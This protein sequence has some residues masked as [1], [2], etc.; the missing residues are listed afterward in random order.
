MAMQSINND[1]FEAEVL[2]S[3]K[4]VIVEFF[5]D[6]CVPCKRMSPVLAELEDEYTEVKFVKLNI[7]FG[8]ETAQKY[9][10]MSSPTFV[11]FK[12]GNEIKRV[13][14]VIARDEFED[15]I[16]EVSA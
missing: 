5:S 6:D 10:V 2:Q 8:A 11:F 4:L 7:G 13:R 15:I 14:G 3:E 16:E 12:D 1:N 9:G